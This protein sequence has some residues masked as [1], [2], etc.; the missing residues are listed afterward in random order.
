[1]ASDKYYLKV[2]KDMAQDRDIEV[3][4]D[5]TVSRTVSAKGKQEDG[6][7]VQAWI[8]VPNG[9]VSLATALKSTDRA[10]G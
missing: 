7:Y 8:W 3:D 2:A 4:D 1:M 9:Q 5:A 10:G 6:A